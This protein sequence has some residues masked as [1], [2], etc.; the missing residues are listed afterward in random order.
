MVR[1]LFEAYRA[2]HL[3]FLPENLIKENLLPGL[4]MLKKDMP[5]LASGDGSSTM[6]G[7][8]VSL[9]TVQ[10]TDYDSMIQEMIDSNLHK[11]K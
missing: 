9:S 3:S 6:T 10:S 2:M 1:C 11:H 7:S 4:Y 8:D 5:L